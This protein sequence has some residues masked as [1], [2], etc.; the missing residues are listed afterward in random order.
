MMLSKF[1][2]WRESSRGVVRAH[3]VLSEL[4]ELCQSARSVVIANEMW[5]ELMRGSCNLG[6]FMN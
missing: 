2:E 4:S 5:S 6:A 1:I 3:G